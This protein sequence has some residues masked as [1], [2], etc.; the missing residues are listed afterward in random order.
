MGPIFEP[1]KC[2]P[3]C[4]TARRPLHI[5]GNYGWMLFKMQILTFVKLKFHVMFYE[6]EGQLLGDE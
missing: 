1:A 4:S 5:R 6:T 3:M 2:T